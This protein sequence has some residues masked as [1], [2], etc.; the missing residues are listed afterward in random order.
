MSS[1][2]ESL[3]HISSKIN[4]LKLGKKEQRKISKG[5]DSWPCF[6]AHGQ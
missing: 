2:V 3:K 6:A 5:Q 1:I 4:W